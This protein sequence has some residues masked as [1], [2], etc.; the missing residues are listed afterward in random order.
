[1]GLE[2]KVLDLGDIELD[3]SFLVLALEQGGGSSQHLGQAAVPPRGSPRS[4][5]PWRFGH[6]AA[7]DAC[8]TRIEN[9]CRVPCQVLKGHDA[10]C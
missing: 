9:S 1:M 10:F 5:R 7:G 6:V 3:T 2:V 4:D 8:L